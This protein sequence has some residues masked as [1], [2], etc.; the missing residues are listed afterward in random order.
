MREYTVPL[1]IDIPAEANLTDTIVRA[2]AETPDRPLL[3]RREGGGWRTVSAAEFATSMREVAAGLLAAGV[4]P[5]DRVGLMSKTRYEWTLVDYA[6]WAIGAVT[7][8]IYETSSAEQVEWILGDSGAVAVVVE[9]GAHADLVAEAKDR[10]PD[11]KEVWRIDAGDVTGLAEQGRVGEAEAVEERRRAVRGDDLATVIY[12]SGTTGRP[13]GCALT[14]RNFLVRALPVPA[15]LD[16]LFHEGGTTL[17]FLPL[18]HI[19]ARV[20]QVGAI[21]HGVVLAHSADM[22]RLLDDFAQFRP[23][24]ILSVPRVFEK[25]FNTARQRANADGK[26]AIFDRAADV[27]VRYSEAMDRGGARPL[28]RLQHGLFDR[29]VYRKLRAAVGGEVSYAVSGGAP[30]GAR[31]GHFFRG[32]GIV[33]LEGYGLTETTAGGTL[34]L[35]NALR[36]G[37]IGRPVPGCTIRIADDGEI[38]IDAEF[39][40]TGYWHNDEATGEA[41]VD[42]WFHTGDIGELDKDGFLRITGRK[43]ELIVTAGGKNVAPAVLEDRLRAHPLISQCMVVGDQKPFVAALVTLDAEALPDWARAHGKPADASAAD[44]V[45]DPDLRADL[46]AAVDEANRAVSQAESIRA[47]RVLAEDFTED[48]GELTPTLKVKRSVVL[49]RHRA[50]VDAIYG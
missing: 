5:G 47:F 3:S 28:L 4:G 43:K 46:Q 31:L 34:N 49:E 13:K 11:L 14:H 35:P 36:I 29:L 8:P 18:A 42:G 45:D 48:T 2:A 39:V 40:F 15:G 10:L 32:V 37:S 38:L 20:V 33:V 9:T 30:L 44:L 24:F 23:T 17:L 26:G 27:A 1:E 22:K 25:I 16:E 50:D 21:E 12:T 19:F 41:V 6:L 7:V